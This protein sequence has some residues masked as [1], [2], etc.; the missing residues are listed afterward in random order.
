M[1]SYPRA[2]RIPTNRGRGAR[3]FPGRAAAR[4][5]R[6]AVCSVYTAVRAILY[7]AANSTSD[8]RVILQRY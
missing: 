7:R 8:T 4:G 3:G 1:L 5:S 2:R 6:G